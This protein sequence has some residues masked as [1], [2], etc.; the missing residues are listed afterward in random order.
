MSGALNRALQRAGSIF[1]DHYHSRLLRSPTEVAN[2][3][4]YVDGNAERHY[5]ERGI[6]PFSSRA[7]DAAGVVAAPRGWL[8]AVGWKR[9]QPNSIPCASG[10]SR[11]KFTVDVCLRM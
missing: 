3:I 1:A 4:R 8:L 10:R 2:A 9:G 7:S 6:D 11:P 5:G